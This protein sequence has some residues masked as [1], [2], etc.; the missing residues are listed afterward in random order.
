MPGRIG[1]ASVHLAG[2][3]GPGVR[4]HAVLG[5]GVLVTGNHRVEVRVHV[6][7]SPAYCILAPLVLVFVA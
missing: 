6:R 7:G 5:V 2:A 4:H 1:A 3:C